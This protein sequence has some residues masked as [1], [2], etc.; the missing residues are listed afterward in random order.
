MI[1]LAGVG[2][3]NLGQWQEWTGFAFHVRRRLTAE[4][5]A[6]T[7]DAIDCRGTDEWQKRYDAMK[8]K[9][10]APAL[11]MAIQEKE[12]PQCQTTRTTRR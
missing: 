10:P 3:A 2:D 9:L 6:I 11:G 5:Q 7:G 8:D 12:R 1:A 4:E